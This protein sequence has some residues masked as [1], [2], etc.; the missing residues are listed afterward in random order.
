MHPKVLGNAAQAVYAGD[1]RIERGRV[2]DVTNLSGSF[3]FDD[4]HGL[5][6]VAVE[7]ELL[8]F[9]VEEGAVRFFPMDGSPPSVLK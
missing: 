8:G 3:Q 4:P 6:S 2:A 9:V 1:L 7:I 5:L